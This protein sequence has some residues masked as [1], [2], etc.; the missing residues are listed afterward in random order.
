IGEP[1]NQRTRVILMAHARSAI[2]QDPRVA[3]IPRIEALLGSTRDEVRL[4]IDVTLI[5]Q[6]TPL[7]LVFDVKLGTT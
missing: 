5:E 2:T 4:E 6:Q 1:N 3:D 7:N